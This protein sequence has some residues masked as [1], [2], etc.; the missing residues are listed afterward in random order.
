MD[1]LVKM[2]TESGKFL[3]CFYNLTISWKIP[4]I[5]QFQGKVRKQ[6][7]LNKHNNK[8]QNRTEAM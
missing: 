6:I 4:S 8:S 3:S 5:N 7:I 1:S 2:G